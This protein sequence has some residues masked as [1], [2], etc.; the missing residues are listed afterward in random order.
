LPISGTFLSSA[1]TNTKE[2]MPNQVNIDTVKLLREKLALAKS[3]AVV[4]YSG[5][6]VNEQ[7]ELRQAL[8]DAGAELKVV[9]NALVKKALDIRDLDASLEG[10]NAFV[11]CNED[12]VGG[13]KALFTFHKESE[14]LVIKQGLM[15]DKVLSS[16]ELTEL[17]KLPGKNQL[18]AMLISRLQG[19]AYGLVNVLK[20]SQRDLV[21]VLKA[22]TEKKPAVAEKTE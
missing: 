17:S 18:I 3:F 9:K 6:S 1:R 15:G 19:P 12:E 5:T 7:V 2:C 11:F 20:A 13:I 22:I 16:D 14:K 8:K 21:C 4:E 10:Q